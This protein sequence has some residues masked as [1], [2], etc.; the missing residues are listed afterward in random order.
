MID[1]FQLGKHLRVEFKQRKKREL[2]KLNERLRRSRSVIEKKNRTINELISILKEQ[3]E[4]SYNQQDADSF[5][6][7][8]DEERSIYGEYEDMTDPGMEDQ[9]NFHHYI[10]DNKITEEAEDEYQ[11]ED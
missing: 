2:R 1:I 10:A 9:N 5:L 4:T 8:D 3:E 7:R 6:Q 11:M